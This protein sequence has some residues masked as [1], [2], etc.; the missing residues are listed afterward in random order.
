MSYAA[1]DDIKFRKWKD[2]ATRHKKLKKLGIAAFLIAGLGWLVFIYKM[3][4]TSESALRYSTEA[5][6]SVGTWTMWLLAML[7]GS[8]ALI[9]ISSSAKKRGEELAATLKADLRDRLNEADEGHRTVIE[10]QLRELGA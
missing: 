8:V 7:I 3:M 6:E 4:Q 10:S 2:V 9:V 5:Q 1:S